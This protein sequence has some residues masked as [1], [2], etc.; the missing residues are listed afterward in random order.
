VEEIYYVL[1]GEGVV[2]IGDESAPVGQDDAFVV[3]LNEVHSIA[4]SGT[5]D[6]VLVVVG[7]A[8]EKWMV[9]TVEVE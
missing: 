4:N 2:T 8:T 9:D 7:A 5:D 3:S 6:L 1:S